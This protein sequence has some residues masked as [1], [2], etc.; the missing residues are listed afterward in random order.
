MAFYEDENQNERDISISKES[1]DKSN[2]LF[3]K[4]L[5]GEEFNFTD[6]LK[7][8][9]ILS[10]TINK[11]K[12]IYQISNNSIFKIFNLFC[13]NKNGEN[14][15][16]LIP[17]YITFN[18]LD[19]N[20]S[21][22]EDLNLNNPDISLGVLDAPFVK[23]LEYTQNYKINIS[24]NPISHIYE[25]KKDLLN[26]EIPKNKINITSKSIKKI[27][28]YLNKSI[29][30]ISD[31]INILILYLNEDDV[32]K[33]VIQTKIINKYSQAGLNAFFMG[34]KNLDIELKIPLKNFKNNLYKYDDLFESTLNKIEN[35]ENNSSDY[36]FEE[37]KEKITNNDDLLDT[38]K[39]F[40]E[41]KIKINK[42]NYDDEDNNDKNNDGKNKCNCQNDICS[43]CNIF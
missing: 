23:L 16:S 3:I 31:Y 39:K 40:I 38:P 4:S 13:D 15:D 12:N 37:N 41:Q 36:N 28:K 1:I 27:C 33:A 21:F 9:M 29:F 24:T 19:D 17:D 25:I 10:I 35:I 6:F 2:S 30:D 43:F 20:A 32:N 18:V 11:T 26:N 8:K 7:D 34:K 22:K 5:N 42:V 14:I